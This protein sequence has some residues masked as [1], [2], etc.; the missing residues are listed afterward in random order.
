MRWKCGNVSL[1]SL[2]WRRTVS[3][4]GDCALRQN[5]DKRKRIT[6]YMR[7]M[8]AYARTLDAPPNPAW[9]NTPPLTPILLSFRRPENMPWL[10]AGFLKL[11]YVKR[12]LVLNNNPAIRL[13]TYTGELDSRVEIA[14]MDKPTSAM[15]RF[16]AAADLDEP[17]FA[18]VDDDVFL[19]G[20]QIHA[21][22]AALRTSPSV[23]HGILG[24]RMILN[25]TFSLQ[26]IWPDK[27]NEPVDM[28]LRCYFLSREVAA[29]FRATRAWAESRSL[30]TT[31]CD[32]VLLSFAQAECPR[33][34]N[35]GPWVNCLSGSHSK[36][37]VF[38]TTDGFDQ[39]RQ[40]LMLA[41]WEHTGRAS[42]WQACADAD[43]RLLFSGEVSK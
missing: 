8:L 40:T 42:Q 39:R 9:K 13:E 41:L 26:R 22:F 43:S 1:T 38:R 24:C 12:I 20:S 25:P 16:E 28:L 14:N 10:L 36:I 37:A 21:L 2:I 27:A 23:P 33:V 6:D 32:D 35:V 11:P 30:E 19:T 31:A 5:L 29:N 4:S 3:F 18:C 17:W 15:V 34:H 7:R